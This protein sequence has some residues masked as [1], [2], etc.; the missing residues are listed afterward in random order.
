MSEDLAAAVADALRGV[1]DPEL[2]YNIVDLGLVYDIAVEAGAAHIRM[3]T[4][5]A[6]C[7]AAAALKHGAEEA[8]RS[9]PGIDTAEVYM[10]WH[11][12]WSPDLMSAAAK[13]RFGIT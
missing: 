9:V 1:I 6:G 2:G 4:T 10:T 5:Q 12:A 7:P 3:T 11:P 8:A 13:E